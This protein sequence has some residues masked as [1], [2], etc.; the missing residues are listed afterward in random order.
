MDIYLVKNVINGVNSV[1]IGHSWR[2]WSKLG[3]FRGKNNAIYQNLEKVVKNSL[4]V[5]KNYF[6]QSYGHIFGQKCHKWGQ[7]G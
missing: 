5:S 6:S 3:P 4:N 1:K 7:L 2:K